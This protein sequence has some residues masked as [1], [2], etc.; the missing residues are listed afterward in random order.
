MCVCGGGGGQK[1]QPP[2]SYQ[3]L[4]FGLFR[5]ESLV[6]KLCFCI[7]FFYMAEGDFYQDIASSFVLDSLSV[8]GETNYLYVIIRHS[9]HQSSKNV[10]I[11]GPTAQ[12]LKTAQD[13]YVL[14]SLAAHNLHKTAVLI[15]FLFQEIETL[16]GSIHLIGKDGP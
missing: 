3:D 14:R 10:Q 1:G 2:P 7:S 12:H 11:D 16:C 6:Q 4:F 9:C 8:Y 5:I 13:S 15:C